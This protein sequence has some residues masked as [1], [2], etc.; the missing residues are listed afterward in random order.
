MEP[1]SN[2]QIPFV[3]STLK[4]CSTELSQARSDGGYVFWASA[5]ESFGV[6]RSLKQSRSNV[7]PKKYNAA[8]LSAA[9]RQS[10]SSTS[11]GNPKAVGDAGMNPVEMMSILNGEVIKMAYKPQNAVWW[12]VANMKIIA[13]TK[14]TA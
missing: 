4:T 14:A 9:E 8:P 11:N 13:A 7:A 2:V 5:F 6:S 3:S 12:A 1:V 10:A